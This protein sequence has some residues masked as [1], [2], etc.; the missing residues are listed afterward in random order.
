MSGT[1]DMTHTTTPSLKSQIA[2]WARAQYALIGITAALAALFYFEGYRPQVARERELLAQ[3]AQMQHDLHTNQTQASRLPAVEADLH[4]LRAQLAGFKKLP[5][6]PELGEFVNQI[7][8]ISHQ[9]NM[10]NLSYTLTAAP[11]PRDQY[12][13]QPVTLKF[14][15][16]FLSVFAFVHQVENLQRLTRIS[17]I[18]V[19]SQDIKDGL[20]HVDMS[21][22]LYY[23][24][25]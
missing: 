10:H 11:R 12:T 9:T 4:H 23:S 6:R 16:D 19:H 2:W 14:E 15:G 7:T 21:M 18:V 17:S 8:L 22:D 24:E 5:A 13:E 25:G 1:L 20:V 3:I